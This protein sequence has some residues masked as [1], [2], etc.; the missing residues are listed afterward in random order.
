MA[1]FHR[2][3]PTCVDK[4]MNIRTRIRMMTVIFS[5]TEGHDNVRWTLVDGDDVWQNVEW[6]FKWSQGF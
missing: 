1:K 3:Y 6:D 2:R 5:R 4:S